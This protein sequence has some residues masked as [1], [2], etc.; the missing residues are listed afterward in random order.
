MIKF[1]DYKNFLLND[2]VI[3]KSQQQFISK[4]HDVY[5]ENVN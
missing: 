3:L 4:K 2:Q 1:N 5:M